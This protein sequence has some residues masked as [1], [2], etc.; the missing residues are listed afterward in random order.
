[1]HAAAGFDVSKVEVAEP[2]FTGEGQLTLLAFP[3]PFLC[4]GSG[5]ALPLLQE[6]PDPVARVAWD[7][8]AELS[9]ATAEKLGVETGDVL[10]LESSAGAIELS[11]LPRGGIRDDVIAVPTGQGHSVGHFA[12]QGRPGPRR[13]RARRERVR[14]AARRRRRRERRA[15]PGSPSARS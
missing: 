13:R 11:A 12:S 15:A 8:W 1:M 3:H 2:V 14:P 10:R 5:A 7:S 4:D 9:L 6:I